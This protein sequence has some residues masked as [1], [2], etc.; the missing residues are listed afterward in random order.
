MCIE[1]ADGG[2]ATTSGGGGGGAAAAADVHTAFFDG[3]ARGNQH[4]DKSRVVA[5]SGALLVAPTGNVYVRR[6]DYLGGDAAPLGDATLPAAETNNAAEYVG[7]IAVLAEARSARAAAAKRG[8]PFLLEV[9]GDSKLVCCQIL[10]EWQ[11]KAPG[12]VPF[13]ARAVADAKALGELVSKCAF[14]ELVANGGCDANGAP[15]AAITFTQV[16]RKL[17]ADADALANRAM[18]RHNSGR[19]ARDDDD[20]G[21]GAALP[22]AKRA[23]I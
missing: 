13:H 20:D 4:A 1:G 12:L 7:V 5:G 18:D 15:V 21:G 6:W 14:D 9:R 11:V 23:R 19:W 8:A 2:A 16:P 3:G 17:N 10:G 22:E